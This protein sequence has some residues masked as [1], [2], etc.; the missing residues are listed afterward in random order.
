MEPAAKKP[1]SRYEAMT[2]LFL[3]LV[4]MTCAYTVIV[5]GF[6]A[7]ISDHRVVHHECGKQFHLWKYGLINLLLWTFTIVSY[8]Y[9]Q[10][11]G[12]G[13]RARAMVLT[14]L[15]TAVCVWGVLLGQHLG[16]SAACWQVIDD[17]FHVIFS[18]HYVC[19]IFDGITAFLLILHEAGLGRSLGADL[20]VYPKIEVWPQPPPPP[21]MDN[22]H[23][24]GVPS[25]LTAHKQGQPAQMKPHAG[26]LGGAPPKN[27]APQISYEYEKIMQ[28]TQTQ[29]SDSTSSMLPQTEP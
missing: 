11:G 26:Y 22:F 19:T 18:Y 15:F 5:M 1:T 27:L 7:L 24:H 21:P 17:R 2:Q 13:A 9:W 20:T 10:A 8:V 14:I 28:N 12:E 29:G 25:A 3:V 4:F 16:H 6:F 23:Y